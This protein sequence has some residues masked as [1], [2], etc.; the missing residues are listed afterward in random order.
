MS[1]SI[2]EV[3]P[4]DIELLDEYLYQYRTALEVS[5]VLE[6]RRK[7][8]MLHMEYPLNG[9]SY[10][11]QLHPE[12]EVSGGASTYPVAKAQIDQ[13]IRDQI[14][15]VAQDLMNIMDIFDQLERGS[16][17]REVLEMHYIDGTPWD[18]ITLRANMSRGTV[19]NRR[20][21]GLEKLLESER[22]QRILI[23]YREERDKPF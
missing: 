23:E 15:L 12:N 17:E 3:I 2:N 9:V 22:V 14:D 4:P 6:K 16:E 8:I 5:S 7:E 18:N 1:E 13:Q 19:Y 10:D 11:P 21:S 20:K